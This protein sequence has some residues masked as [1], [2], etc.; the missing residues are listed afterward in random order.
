MVLRSGTMHEGLTRTASA[1]NGVLKIWKFVPMSMTRN[2]TTARAVTLIAV[3]LSGA[4]L[5]VLRDIFTPLVMALFLLLMIDGFARGMRRYVA[6]PEGLAYFLAIFLTLA[7]FTATVWVISDGAAGIVAELNELPKQ[8]D[9]FLLQISQDFGIRNTLTFSNIIQ[10]FPLTEYAGRSLNLLR[11][12]ASTI[13][14]VLIYLGFLVASR[15]GFSRKVENLFPTPRAKSNAE[16]I[17]N[18]VRNGV[19]NY[20]WIQTVTGIIIAVIAWGMMEAIGLNNALFWAFVI[21]IVCYIPI[22]GG[23]IAGLAP[24]LFALIQLDSYIPAVI[25]LVGLQALLFIMGNLV[26]PRMQSDRENIDPI[27]ILL[28]LAFWGAMWGAIGMFLS[29]PLAVLVMAILAEFKSTRWISVL[30]SADGNPYPQEK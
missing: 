9:Y 1:R 28:A 24:P 4:A 10:D 20:L 19:E 16:E 29:T 6:I 13:V 26:Q 17:F 27:A 3:I 15:A 14:F 25:L 21:F 8:I 12:T 30:L 2:V 5:Y 11:E 18:R 23:A 22:L 7:G